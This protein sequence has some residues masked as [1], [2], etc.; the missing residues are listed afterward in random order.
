MS[1]RDVD[2]DQQIAEYLRDGRENGKN[3]VTECEN[4]ADHGKATGHTDFASESQQDGN[5]R[6]RVKTM[7]R[8]QQK[9]IKSSAL[10]DRKKRTSVSH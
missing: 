7:A 8:E 3:A 10:Y 4:C 9:P 6:R 2:A 5:K 1:E